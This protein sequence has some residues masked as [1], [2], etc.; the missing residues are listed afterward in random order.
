MI[1][2]GITGVPGSGKTTLSR[3]IASK[4]RYI[5]E[6]KH[7]ELV[8][9]YARRYISK[10]G[11]V[12]SIFEQYRILEKQLEW[13][14]SVCNDKLDVMVTDSPVFLGFI[15][16]CELPKS[17]SKEIMFFNDVFKKMVKINCPK[18]RYDIVLHLGP[19]GHRPVDD[20]IRIADHLDDKWRSKADTMIRATMEIFK[21]QKL[22]EVPHRDLEDM[23][24]WCIDEIRKYST[25]TDISRK[26]TLCS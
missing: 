19:D 23:V 7:I 22:I 14:D 15:Y 21:P 10:H 25:N 24:G 8:N 26:E 20:G 4:C 2:V 16:C 13:E 5:E 6:F 11:P 17:N 1:K 3:A 12:T 9:E 18:P